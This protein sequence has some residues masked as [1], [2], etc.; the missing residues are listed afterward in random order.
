[1]TLNTRPDFELRDYQKQ[2]ITQTYRLIR[3]AMSGK[4]SHK[5]TYSRRQEN[6]HGWVR[7]AIA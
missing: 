3:F 1:V 2:A 4:M 5:K 7:G 6:V